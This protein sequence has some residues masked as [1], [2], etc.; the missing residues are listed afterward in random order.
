[1][2]GSGSWTSLD[3]RGKPVVRD[4][5]CT[6]QYMFFLNEHL[7]EYHSLSIPG[8]SSV[9]VANQV[10]EGVYDKVPPTAFQWR[11]LMSPVNQL[12]EIGIFVVYG[13]LIHKNPRR[14]ERIRAI[15]G[16]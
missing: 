15:T 12:A 10:T 4:D 2:H 11:D 9:R 16:T 1:M 7:L 14:N 5:K 13:Q 3:Y 8:L 6:A